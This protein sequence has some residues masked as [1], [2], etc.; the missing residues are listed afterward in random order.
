MARLLLLPLI[1]MVIGCGQG[2]IPAPTPLAS[3]LTPEATPDPTPEPTHTPEPTPTPERQPPVLRI[4]PT[5]T[6]VPPGEPTPTPSATPT[7]I[8]IYQMMSATPKARPMITPRPKPPVLRIAPTVTPV[9]P[10]EP[11]PIPSATPTLI[12]IYQ[13]ISDYQ[14]T[15]TARPTIT[16]RPTSTS[17]PLP[18]S[19]PA[20]IATIEAVLTTVTPEPLSDAEEI[21]IGTH[22]I[23]SAVRAMS[24]ETHYSTLVK[25][26]TPQGSELWSMAYEGVN[27]A[28][29]DNWRASGFLTTTGNDAVGAKFDST[30]DSTCLRITKPEEGPW[31]YMEHE[32][33]LPV[34]IFGH[35]QFTPALP[36]ATLRITH[37]HSW[38][39]VE[40]TG[41]SVTLRID[42]FPS[43]PGLVFFLVV[44]RLHAQVDEE[45]IEYGDVQIR[46]TYAYFDESQME[47]VHK[48]RADCEARN[49]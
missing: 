7:L 38:R 47:K 36:L 37:D 20:L 22:V 44:N 5:V 28:D 32:E 39:V 6:P 30:I 42:P 3:V 25:K 12:P 10:G 11:T 23:N 40:T 17:I 1:I 9:P 14:A 2:Q 29:T 26:E 46:T 43:N 33:W 15:P 45:I 18:A 41:I 21:A 24:E 16:S 4:A 13:M 34:S 31:T 8:P 19:T 35:P 27:S 48:G 49:S